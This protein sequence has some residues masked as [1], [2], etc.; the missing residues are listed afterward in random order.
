[1]NTVT[2]VRK[3][4]VLLLRSRYKLFINDKQTS[5]LD[6]ETFEFPDGTYDFRVE[7]LFFKS[8][9][10][11]LKLENNQNVTIYIKGSSAGRHGRPLSIIILISF[12]FF[13]LFE[14]VFKSDLSVYF[15][16]PFLLYI[17]M[18]LY[19]SLFERKKDRI[20]LYVK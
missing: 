7:Q 4:E 11:S 10:L 13:F 5:I 6:K 19:T 15:L 16:L 20:K 8:N 12:F 1:M 9:T 18:P 3:A 2:I 17:L 14:Y